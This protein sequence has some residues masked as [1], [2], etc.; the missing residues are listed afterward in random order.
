MQDRFVIAM[1]VQHDVGI[2]A[3]AQQSQPERVDLGQSRK[4]RKGRAEGIPDH[5]KVL[6]GIV[7]QSRGDCVL[8]EFGKI[9]IAAVKV[10][11]TFEVLAALRLVRYPLVEPDRIGQRDHPDLARD[12]S[13]GGVQVSF[14]MM[15]DGH[16]RRLVGME[17]RLDVDLGACT[18]LSP[19]M[20][21]KPMRRAGYVTCDL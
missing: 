11:H 18:V 2:M 16:A 3:P 21:D 9:G 19:N 4:C 20:G 5:G 8:H 7:G 1:Q 13:L 6:R 10:L 15:R 14:Q 12:V 17:A